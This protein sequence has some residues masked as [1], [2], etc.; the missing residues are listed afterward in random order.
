MQL[1]LRYFEVWLLKLEG[2]LPD[3][4]HCSDCHR[5][6]TEDETLYLGSESDCDVERAVEGL[7]LMCRERSRLSFAQC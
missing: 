6:F 3:L 1:V 2:F 7:V 5:A 4:K